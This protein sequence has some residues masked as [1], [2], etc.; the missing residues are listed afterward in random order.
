[1]STTY[2]QDK[3][4]DSEDA[5]L[6]A[7]EG[8]VILNQGSRTFYLHKRRLNRSSEEE[9]KDLRILSPPSTVSSIEDFE[10]LPDRLISHETLEYLGFNEGAAN[11]IWSR[12]ANWGPNQDREIDG[13]PVSFESFFVTYVE[14]TGNDTV[15][16][17]DDSW[18]QTMNTIGIKLSFQAAMMTP[19][20]KEIRLTESCKFWLLDTIRAKYSSLEDIQKFSRE[21]AM[22]ARRAQLRPNAGSSGSSGSLAPQQPLLPGQTSTSS[23]SHSISNISSTQP[24]ASPLTA[25]SPAARSNAPGHSVLYKGGYST[26][27]LKAFNEQGKI[28]YGT[29]GSLQS[30]SPGDFHSGQLALY[31]AL[32]FD[33]AAKYAFWAKKRDSSLAV[34]I[35]RLEMPNAAIE[36]LDETEKRT[37]YWPSQEWKDLVW[38]CR[39][40]DKF[41]KQLTKFQKPTVI[42]GSICGKPD[43]VITSLSSSDLIKNSMVLQRKDGGKAVQYA[44]MHIQGRHFVADHGVD[45]CSCHAVTRGQ[46]DELE[47][48]LSN[49]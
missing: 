42:I 3:L 17:D 32:D 10:E 23:S 22:A 34:S 8:T 13:G 35:L 16:D 2:L 21:R 47:Q 18:W 24:G 40:D 12:W 4:L 19:L 15:S 43:E 45:K 7:Q 29:L 44:F 31:L 33:I 28:T 14:N 25:V 26:R 49:I 11:T 37:V 5:Q 30:Q 27:L 6:L 9:Y 20:C 1:M 41:P 38:I 39:R 36:A 48:L 46:L